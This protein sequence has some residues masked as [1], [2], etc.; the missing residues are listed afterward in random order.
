MKRIWISLSILAVVFAAALANS[1]YL[2]TLTEQMAHTLEEAQA[3][4]EAEDW[5][6]G[7]KLTEKALKQWE[8]ASNYL[9]IVVRHS[10]SDEVAA[11]FREIRQLLEWKEEAE[12]T[13]ANARLIEEIRLLADMEQFTLRNLL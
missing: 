2:D 7:Q 8:K 5:E 10:D 6:G 12:Y 11:G 9:Y 1:W 4:A 13:S 3:L